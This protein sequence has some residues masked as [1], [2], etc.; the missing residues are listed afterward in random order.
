[1]LDNVSELNSHIGV[2]I[3]THIMVEFIGQENYNDLIKIIKEEDFF[4]LVCEKLYDEYVRQIQKR[5]LKGRVVLDHYLDILQSL[6]KYQFEMQP[7]N[8]IAKIQNRKDQKHVDCAINSESKAWIIITNDSE[9]FK[10]IEDDPGIPVI[11]NYDEFKIKNR[12]ENIIAECRRHS[13]YPTN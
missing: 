9:D 3:D 7:L 13:L 1:M 2:L 11:V 5:F 10:W 8:S 12:R 6:G 4:L